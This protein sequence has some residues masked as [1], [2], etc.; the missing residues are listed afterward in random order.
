MYEVSP[1]NLLPLRA[2][3]RTLPLFYSR[4][5]KFEARTYVQIMWKSI[6]RQG[7]CTF[8]VSL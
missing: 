1:A 6:L 3:F 7:F 4:T 5:R 2:A 8:L